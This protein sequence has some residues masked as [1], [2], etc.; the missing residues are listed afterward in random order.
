[1]G[2]YTTYTLSATQGHDNQEEIE[3][4]LQQMSGY[5]IGF[6]RNDPCKW[7]IHEQDMKELSKIYPETTFL[8]EGQGEESEDIWRKYFKNGKKQVCKAKIVFPAF[9]ESKLV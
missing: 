8:L 1:M 6:G 7:Y 5:S 9:D 2:Y 4:K 3:E